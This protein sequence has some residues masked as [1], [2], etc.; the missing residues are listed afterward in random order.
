MKLRTKK[1]L[2]TLFILTVICSVLGVSVIS[3]DAKVEEAIAVGAIETYNLKVGDTK[4]IFLNESDKVVQSAVWKSNTPFDVE[5]ISQDSVSC[6]VRVNNY[7][8]STA[9]ITCEYYYQQ[10]N[11]L[12]GQIWL[13][14]GA[15]SF[16]VKVSESTGAD[17][18]ITPEIPVVPDKPKGPFE[19]D[20]FT[21][22]IYTYVIKSDGTAEVT[23][24]EP[25]L[26]TSIRIPKWMDDYKTTSVGNFAFEYCKKLEKVTLP[27]EATSI[28]RKAFYDCEKLHTVVLP[29][30]LKEIGAGAFMYCLKLK[31][32]TIPQGVNV[33]EQ[34]VFSICTSL[35]SITLPEGVTKIERKAFEACSS[36]EK[37]VM[38]ESIEAIDANAFDECNK[39]KLVVYGYNG[40]AAESF[41]EEYGYNFVS[42]KKLTDA[43]SGLSVGVIAENEA[44]LSVKSIKNASSVDEVN[45]SL[46]NEVAVEIYDI[47]LKNSQESEVVAVKIATDNEA[48][49]VYKIEADGK[50]TKINTKFNDG[51]ITFNTNVLGKIVLAVDGSLVVPNESTIS[52]EPSET[53]KPTDNTI[54]STSVYTEQTEILTAPSTAESLV[55]EP[56][57]TTASI[58]TS[59]SALPTEG[60]EPDFTLGDV[61]ADGKINIKDATTIQKFVAKMIELDEKAQ[62]RADYNADG[63]INVKDATQI[64]KKIANLL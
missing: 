4:Y 18:P 19:M 57:S 26:E 24:Y 35:E 42:I 15:K 51:Y 36:L 11:S 9:I 20:E 16:Y 17:K 7:I 55:T 47:S 10:F 38:P 46:E 25:K 56:A 48:V 59:T 27:E 53:T 2:S 5:I 29:Q 30:G 23:D 21:A 22:G 54:P 8:S 32:I 14:K 49:K 43:E 60:T 12:T 28:G 39:E 44:K 50:L 41:A 34:E 62:A 13:M 58:N 1:L 63:K 40:T 52:T 3:S 6:Q 37:V 61:N 45:H 31:E 33:I 64:Q